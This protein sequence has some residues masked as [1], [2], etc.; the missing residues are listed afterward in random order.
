MSFVPLLVI[1]MLLMLFGFLGINPSAVQAAATTYFVTDTGASDASCLSTAPCSLA[2][3]VTLAQNGDEIRVAAGTYKSVGSEPVLNVTESLTVTGG[4]LYNSGTGTWSDTADPGNITTL[5]GNNDGRVVAIGVGASPIIENFHIQ[6]GRSQDGAGI[7]IADGDGRPVIRHNAIHHNAST[8][9]TLGGGGIYDGGGSTIAYNDIYSN[10]ATANGAGIYLHNASATISSTISFNNISKNKASGNGTQLGGGVFMFFNAKGHFV[11]NKIFENSADI[12]GGLGVN[13]AQFSMYSNLLYLNEAVNSATSSA[14]GGGIYSS[15]SGVIWNNTIASNTAIGNGGGLHLEFGTVAM[16]N[17]IIALNTSPGNNGL[18]NDNNAPAS[19]SGTFN[20][21]SDTIDASGV[22]FTNNVTGDP[23]FVNVAG[24]NY[25][26]TGGSAAR[27]SGSNNT[28]VNIDID[29]QPRPNPTDSSLQDVGADE[30]YQDFREVSIAPATELNY[31]ERGTTAVFTHT[32]RND[33]SLN[34]TYVI[35]CANNKWSIASCATLIGPIP[36]GE[37]RSFSTQVLIPGGAAAYEDAFTTITATSQADNAVF[38][39]AIVNSTVAPHPG[40]SFTPN[41]TRTELPGQLITLTHVLTNTGDAFENFIVTIDFDPSQWAKLV[42]SEPLT[43]GLNAGHSENVQVQIQVA[44]DA[45]A[46]FENIVRLKATSEFSPTIF[47]TVVNTITAKATVGTRYVKLGASDDDNN[48]TQPSK[49]CGSITQAVGQAASGDEIRI[50]PG[51]Y[52]EHG[53]AI[54]D[55]FY[56]SGG[57]KTFKDD[58][59]G[60]EPDP[61]L[62][63]INAEKAGRVFNINKQQPEFSVLTLKNGSNGNGGAA[64]IATGAEPKF[65]NVVFSGNHAT[66][67]GGAL[68]MNSGTAVSI[69]KS[70]FI[71]N[72]SAFD[73]GAIQMTGGTLVLR[74]SSFLTNTANSNNGG[75]FAMNGGS[76]S[77]QNNLF[78]NNETLSGNGGSVSLSG[79]TAVFNFNTWVGNSASGNGGGVFNNG[80]TLTVTNSIFSE[81]D[82]SA[83]SGIFASSGSTDLDYLDM[84]QNDSNVSIGS[85]SFTAD[86]MFGDDLFRLDMGSPAIDAANPASTLAVDFEDDDRPSDEGYDIGYDERAG[87]R[88][89]RGGI[90]YGSIQAAVDVNSTDKTILV[91]GIC[92]GVHTIEYDS[93]TISQ[94]VHLTKSLT[95]Q[96]G[97]NSDFSKRFEEPTQ[98]DPEGR[99]RAFFISDGISVTIEAI[100]VTN[101]SAAGLGGGPAGEDAGGAFYNVDG[102]VTLRGVNVLTG[103]AVLGGGFYN[104]AGKPR[105]TW[106]YIERDPNNDNEESYIL[107]ELAQG[108]AVSGGGVY[109]NTGELVVDG[110]WLHHNQA[111]SGGGLFNLAGPITVTNAIFDNNTAANGGGLYNE[112]ATA[113]Y[114]HLTVYGNSATGNGGGFYN[115]AGQPAIYSSIFESNQATGDGSAIYDAVIGTGSDPDYNYYYNNSGST[116][117]GTVTGT[118][119]IASLTAPGLTDPALGDFHL[120]EDAPATD[121][122]DPLSPITTDFEDDPRPSNQ[123]FDIGADETV[124]CLVQVGNTIYGSLQSAINAAQPGAVIKVSGN[125]SGVHPFDSGSGSGSVCGGAM[126]TAVHITKELTLLGGWDEKF[127][128][129]DEDAYSV[130]NAKTLGRVMYIGQG[131]SVTVE[132][133]ALI[134]GVANNGA[135]ICIDDGAQPSLRN[136]HIY[137]NTASADGAGIYSLN[138]QTLLEG[139]N[140]LYNNEATGNGGALYLTGSDIVTAT[141][142]NNFIY[143]NTAAAGA[144]I[145]NASGDHV[146]W[147]NTLYGNIASAAGGGFAIPDGS[148]DIRG[149]ILMA[150]EAGS[151]SGAINATTSGS[152]TIDYN[153]YYQN[154]PPHAPLQPGDISVNPNFANVVSGVFTITIDSPVVDIEIPDMPL[155]TDFEGDIR[156]SHQAFDLGADEVG[157]CFAAIKG[158]ENI[159]FGSVQ[160]AVE[161]AVSGDTILVDGICQNVNRRLVGGNIISQTVLITKN[162]TI[163]GSWEHPDDTSTVTTTLQ[164]NDKGRVVYIDSSATVTIT[165]IILRDGDASAAGDTNDNGG[166]I[167]NN[168]IL[169]FVTAWVQE[170][171][172]VSGGGIFNDGI[173]T[174][175]ESH[176]LTNTVTQN[177]SGLYNNASATVQNSTLRSN[178]AENNGGGIHQ[179]AGSL[180]V[181]KNR[182]YANAADNDGAGVYLNS[183]A[184]ISPT[185][186]NNFIYNNN[187]DKGGGIYNANTNAYI[188]HNTLYKNTAQSNDGAGLATAGGNPDIRNNIIDRNNGSGL[189]SSGGL[190]KADYNNVIGNS[191]GNYV[192]LS[193][194]GGHDI[195]QQ[196]SYVSLAEQNFHLQQNSPGEDV[197][198]LTVPVV[199]DID[200]DQRP[201]NGGPDIGADEI[202]SC[203]VRVGGEGGEI[204][205]VLQD[206]ID[207]AYANNLTSIEIA[208][209]EC[210]GVKEVVPGIKQVGYITATL[211]F[212]GSLRRTDFA[213]LGDYYDPDIRRLTTMINADDEGHVL[214]IANGASPTFYQIAFVDGNAAA[215]GGIHGGAIHKAGVG[216][217]GFRLNYFCDSTAQNGGGI[218]INPSAIID[219]TGA[220]VGDCYVKQIVEDEDGNVDELQTRT[221]HFNGNN[222]SGNGGGFYTDGSMSARNVGVFENTAGINGGG[223]YTDEN[224]NELINVVFFDNVAVGLG[225]GLYNTGSNVT[226]LHNTIYENIAND[227]GGIYNSGDDFLLNSSIVYTNTAVS[228]IGGGISSVGS[229]TALD[230]NNFYANTP[231]DHPGLTDPHPIIGEPGL[232]GDP[233]TYESFS[234][235]VHSINIDRADPNLLLMP[236]PIIY[237]YQLDV[238]PDGDKYDMYQFPNGEHSDVGADEYYKD[239][240]CEITASDKAR[241]ATPGDVV[242]YTLTIINTGNPS[243]LDEEWPWDSNGY[244]DTITVTISSQT[245]GWSSL[246]GGNAQSVVLGWDD[247]WLGEGTERILT[248]T[249]PADTQ[250]GTS[251]VTTVMCQ[252][253]SLLNAKDSTTITTNVG[254]IGGVLVTPDYIDTAIPGEVRVYTQT[255]TNLQNQQATYRLTAKSG[256]QHA[257]AVLLNP[258]TMLPVPNITVTLQP[259]GTVGYTTTAYL[260]VTILETAVAG[261]IANPGLVATDISSEKFNSSNNQTTILSAPATRYVAGDSGTN[262]TNC[263][264]PLQPCATIQYA[265]QMAHDADG[266]VDEIKVAAFTYTDYTTSTVASDTLEQVL[267]VNKSVS[268]SGGYTTTEQMPFTT[269]DPINNAV[270][271]DG[272]NT[273]RVIYVTDGVTPTLSSLFIENGNAAPFQNSTETF[274]S[275]IYNAG[276]NLTLYSS[277]IQN[278]NATYGAGLFHE[279]GLLTLYSTILANNSN[280][281]GEIGEGG[282]LYIAAG[283]GIIENNTFANNTANS[284][285]APSRPLPNAPAAANTGFGGGIFLDDP[286]EATVLNNIF[287]NNAAAQGTAIYISGTATLTN[288]YNLYYQPGPISIVEGG[289]LD[290]V[291]ILEDPQFVSFDDFHILGS[292]PAKDAGTPTVSISQSVDIDLE[293]R[294][295]GVQI[296][297]GADEWTQKPGFVFVPTPLSATIS[298]GSVMT[299]NHWLTNTGNFTDSYALTMAHLVTPAG[300]TTWDY[301]LEPTS[302]ID[303]PQSTGVQVTLVVTGG[304]PGYVDVTTITAE[305]ASLLSASVQD[306]TTISQTAGVDI[307]KSEFGSG[308][309]GQLVTYTHTL[310]NTGDG[311]DEFMLTTT[312]VPATWTTTL[313]PTQ[314]VY[315]AADASI[316]FTVTVLIPADAISGTQHQLEVTATATNPDASDILTDTTTV[317]LATGLTLEPNYTRPVADGTPTI[318]THTLTSYSNIADTIA[319]TATGD[320]PGWLVDI[321]PKSVNLNPTESK[322]ISVT[323][324]VPPDTGGLTHITQITA[325]SSLP[326]IMAT[327][328]DTTTV[329]VETGILFTPHLT[330]SVYAGSTAPY[331]HTLTN[332]GNLTDT[333]SLTSNSG[334]GWLQSITPGP[335]EVGPGASVPVT[336]VISVP[337]GTPVGIVDLLGITATSQTV[338][339]TTATVTDTTQVIPFVDLMFTPHHD[340]IGDP[341]TIKTYTHVLTNT[342][343]GEDTFT[344]TYSGVPAWTV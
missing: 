160:Q 299:Y 90:I 312:A 60:D 22:S 39:R 239:F 1:F 332:L 325:T 242:T 17:T 282:G 89:R 278:N 289:S 212:T 125:C 243:Y 189:F 29:G 155:M 58:G 130:L 133:F 246:E 229:N 129:Q 178:K 37:T 322:I 293:A 201:T 141:V 154:D 196:P 281:D 227:G 88:T 283:T 259:S 334:Q 61:T 38:A 321:D 66:T 63:I 200:G 255:V 156:P 116:I 284:E 338:M 139:G 138:S 300:D 330:T 324:T 291:V 120:I 4:Y 235:S 318:Y 238:R 197:G 231:G 57:W 95:I 286:A 336:A 234:L 195:S 96:G 217:V 265:I 13:G 216:K 145:Y 97:W 54:N 191:W 256:L 184:A 261:D 127:K 313:T 171:T 230:Y 188:W 343:D 247:F 210:R 107:T 19:V 137:S 280:H 248:V 147:H 175:D 143:N 36:P 192:P 72:T 279:D 136:N 215:G 91:S 30:Y 194:Q 251:E 31:V 70:L 173:L 119:S 40:I 86:P 78:H 339:T 144:G 319:L 262:T 9:T 20:L 298:S 253:Q 333:F 193:L 110:A 131:I 206:A 104:D 225:G 331:T 26:I 241:Q 287:S 10:T 179:Q 113:N 220:R 269:Q 277:W 307:E 128:S 109:N 311:L 342:G 68:F 205:G 166:G 306:T 118:N 105:L 228:G 84:W 226:V 157:G 254:E 3:A 258:D 24:Q 219:I 268:I 92:R 232:L 28:D 186:K 292:S 46:G 290:A 14:V 121:V 222:A 304:Q 250:A 327:A 48:C 316:P 23:A 50:A 81:N 187:A 182:I 83:G 174:V 41:Y 69:D 309:S 85:H 294:F 271:L 12:G 82:A 87:C 303:L 180:I 245:Q 340:D 266:N 288:N 158:Q 213:D 285:T 167:Y 240:G 15:G 198:D 249:V 18:N 149:N 132:N 80:A 169:N 151:G 172:A 64:L 329:P 328:T 314:P 260:Q 7:Y 99:G 267:F 32:I 177:G 114:L 315:V 71:S 115:A 5:D 341:G 274:G 164:A 6:N 148:P 102:Q 209:G 79:G 344:L 2:R 98:V 33:G 159:V 181:D 221:I 134:N 100:S 94:T 21:L 126:Q 161:T 142:Q 16:H 112:A 264:D 233:A 11:G 301:R 59:Q 108:T 273:R 117:F 140:H 252:S 223:G 101:G 207:H 42:S 76:F 47:A 62:T 208:R 297:I 237:D 204:F 165:N 44:A 326:G 168:G 74:Q 170:N 337:P 335:L 302:I 75:A 25:H 45:D 244:T 199:D 211:H 8:S 202:N 65:N 305:S 185:I 135:G 236:E 214:Y 43:V 296:D 123:G 310:T 323:V 56:I 34:D 317:E 295:M 153:D 67:R 52:K 53:I 308:V 146:Y 124:G 320:L 162:L 176:I 35:S 263:A 190:P 163:N 122:A 27:N 103:T 275:G 183:G 152:P 272:Q 150:N 270:I 106:L 77:G 257:S 73:G 55:V 93:Q 218:Y 111:T 51:E 49:P 203:L 224:G 276:A